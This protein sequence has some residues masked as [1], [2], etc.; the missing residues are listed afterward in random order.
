[1]LEISVNRTSHILYRF[2]YNM[3]FV[4]IYDDIGFHISRNISSI[5][6]ASSLIP[7]QKDEL[8]NFRK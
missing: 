4:R 1:M 2:R 7:L 5:Y 6:Y 3:L 8:D